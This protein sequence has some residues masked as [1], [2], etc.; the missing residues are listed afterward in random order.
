MTKPAHIAVTG[1]TGHLGINLLKELLNQG[2]LVKA[3]IRHNSLPFDH[4]NLSWIRGDLENTKALEELT[5]NCQ[6]LV[7]SASAISLGEK[8]QDLVYKVNVT[9]TQN[10]LKACVN[11]PIRFLYI[12]SSTVAKDPA[13]NEVFDENT[14]YRSDQTFFY[15]WTKALAEQKVLAS[16]KNDHLDACILRPTAIIGPEDNSPSPFGKTILDLHKGTLPFI[17]DGGY[18]LVDVRDLVDTIIASITKGRKGGIY[19]LGGTYISLKELARMTNETKIPMSLPID[20]LLALLPVIR[21]YDRIFPLKWPISKESLTTLKKAP[22]NM[23]CLKA[24]N[25]LGHKNRP[26]QQSIDQL[27]NWF[28]NN[29]ME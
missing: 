23:D 16:V 6:A 2:F 22:K 21:L 19:L 14:P 11:R 9:G 13:N 26:L 8:D 25:D 29:K 12:S 3:L 28:I 10:L 15:A 1:A 7:H 5:E 18:N 27:L 4:K 17:T 20:F 24:T